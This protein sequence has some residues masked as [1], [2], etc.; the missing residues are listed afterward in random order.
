MSAKSISKFHASFILNRI[1]DLFVESG[2]DRLRKH[3]D[4]NTHDVWKEKKRFKSNP[5]H[6][7][8]LLDVIWIA[9][10]NT[11]NRIKQS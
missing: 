5:L 2:E 9:I 6:H 10:G 3:E 8:S 7:D 4:S 1:L 11:T